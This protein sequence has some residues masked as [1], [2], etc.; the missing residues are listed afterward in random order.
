M[1]ASSGVAPGV[2]LEWDDET[3]KE[4]GVIRLK[5]M[6]AETPFEEKEGRE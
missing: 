3:E 6:P 2:I 5:V 4:T 1:R